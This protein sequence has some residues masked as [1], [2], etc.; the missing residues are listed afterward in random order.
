MKVNKL[1]TAIAAIIAGFAGLSAQNGTLTPY[2][3][4]GYG[5]LSDHATSTQR[6][7]GGIGYAMNSGRQINVMNPHLTLPL[8]L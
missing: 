2:S 1:I 6:A 3:R 8:T 4:Y 5:I 7:L